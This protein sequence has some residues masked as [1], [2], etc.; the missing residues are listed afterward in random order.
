MASRFAYMVNIISLGARSR[1][2]E[3]ES[4]GCPEQKLHTIGKSFAE[5]FIIQHEA[6]E[7]LLTA[8]VEVTAMS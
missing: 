2:A 3:F 6:R 7:E 5:H 1:F 8:L 4:Q